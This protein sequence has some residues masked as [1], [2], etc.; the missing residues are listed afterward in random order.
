MKRANG[1]GSITSNGY[2][3]LSVK[4][5]G[6]HVQQYEHILIVERI[7]GRRLPDGAEVHHVNEIKT[8]NRNT[9]LVVCPSHDYHALLHR[10]AAAYDACGHPDWRKCVYC[11]QYD[12][13]ANLTGSVVSGSKH[14]RECLRQYSAERYRLGL[15]VRQ[16]NAS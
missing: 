1:F 5:D 6:T 12:D 14:H 3:K 13:P 16:R 15:T 11:R 7:I 2:R 9:N 4:R 8:D 10:R